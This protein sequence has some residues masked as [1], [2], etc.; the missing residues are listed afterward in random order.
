MKLKRHIEFINESSDINTGKEIADYIISISD[1]SGVPDYSIEKDVLPNNFKLVK[2]DI[3]EIA[4][5]DP[6]FNEYF[7]AGEDRYED[8][9]E[10]EYPAGDNLYNPVVIVD[11][12]VIDGYNRMTMLYKLGEKKVDAYIN[13]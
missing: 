12:S 9:F 4:G 8:Y 2:L 11:D 5:K 10:D 1:E 13:I 7:E 3:K 6:D